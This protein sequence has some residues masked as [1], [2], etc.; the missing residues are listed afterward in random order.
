L[1]HGLEPGV[2]HLLLEAHGPTV[3]RWKLS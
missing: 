3:F 1:A 2:N